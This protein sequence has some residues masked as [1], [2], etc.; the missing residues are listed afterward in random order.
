MKEKLQKKDR[1]HFSSNVKKIVEEKIIKT[2][3]LKVNER[4]LNQKV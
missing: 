3:F 2:Y 1:L 4:K